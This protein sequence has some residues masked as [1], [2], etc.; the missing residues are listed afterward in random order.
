MALSGDYTQRQSWEYFSFYATGNG[1]M[2]ESFAPGEVFVLNEV[3]LTLSVAFASVRDFIITLSA[4]PSAIYNHK[5]V[6]QAMN[7]VR[8][9]LYVP[10]ASFVFASN[11]VLNFSM[12]QSSAIVWGLQITGWAVND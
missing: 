12:F 2:S 8:D 6:S 7:T 4:S 1:A 11:E 3:R 9:F 5:F 10:S